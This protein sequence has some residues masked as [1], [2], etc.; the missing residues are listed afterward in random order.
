MLENFRNKCA[1]LYELDPAN[2]LSAS[3]LAWQ[4]SLKKAE[5]ELELL[6]NADMLLMVEKSIRGGIC[7]SIHRYA[8]AND[9]YMKN[10]DKNKESSYIQY[11]AENNLYG[12]V[13]SQKLFVDMF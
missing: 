13:M 2:F 8:K 12:W 9:K 10:Y 3:G 11:L 7:H 5:V 4:A 1:E 6:T